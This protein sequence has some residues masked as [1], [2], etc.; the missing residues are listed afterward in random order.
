MHPWGKYR[1]ESFEGDQ[2]TIV[3]IDS[4]DGVEDAFLVAREQ[5][6]DDAAVGDVFLASLVKDGDPS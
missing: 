3:R 1:V 4:D 6:G 2:A 5:L